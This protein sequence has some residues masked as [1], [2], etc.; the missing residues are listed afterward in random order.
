M[1]HLREV[2]MPQ[3]PFY[4]AL[5]DVPF[6]QLP[7]MDRQRLQAEFEQI[8]T[9]NLPR[10][11]AIAIAQEAETEANHSALLGDVAVCLSPGTMGGR[12]VFLTEQHER[13]RWATQMLARF[14]P[15]PLLKRHRAA[16]FIETVNDL[17]APVR[18]PL[19]DLHFYNV[20]LGLEENLAALTAQRP[21]VIAAPVRYLVQLAQRKLEGRLTLRPR[22]LIALAEVMTPSD[23]Q[24]IRAAFGIIPQQVYHAWEG[25]IGWS[26]PAGNLHL[27]ERNLIIERE[28]IDPQTG[29]FQPIIT[30][31]HREALPII[32]YRMDDVLV[33]SAE[34]CPCGCASQRLERIEGR[35]QDAAYWTSYE[36]GRKLIPSEALNRMAMT[37]NVPVRDYRIVMRGDALL[38]IHL[39]TQQLGPASDELRL[40]LEQL[41]ELHGCYLPATEFLQGLPKRGN[42]RRRLLRHE[43]VPASVQTGLT[44]GTTV[45]PS[46]KP[47]AGG[48][49]EK[50]RVRSL[51]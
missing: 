7:I 39:D 12:S 41:A 11:K 2:V 48:S 30:D 16:V 9:R 3:S 50:R 21:N 46:G 28:V 34:P 32:R 44:D 27:N 18:K 45:P 25:L 15:A 37:L 4:A 6:D 17:H 31:L 20:R 33:P 49:V 24:L 1:R 43:T 26:C 10:S 29:A 5:V 42:E 19:L 51:S 40:R 14:L 36:G 8:N 35:I 47:L 38:R 22:R 13:Q 23:V